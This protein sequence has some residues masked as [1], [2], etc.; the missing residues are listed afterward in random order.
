MRAGGTGTQPAGTVIGPAG[1][2]VIG[3]N[4]ASVVIPPGA[5]ATNTTITIAQTSAGS[6]PLPG[7]FTSFGPM[8]AFTPHGTTFAVPVTMTLPF[9]P[10]SVP[11]GVTPALLQDERAE[12][13]GAGRQRHV[14]RQQRERAGHELLA[15][16]RGATGPLDVGDP[17]REWTFSDFRQGDERSSRLPATG[18]KAARGGRRLRTGSSEF[19]RPIFDVSHHSAAT[20]S[21]RQTGQRPRCSRRADG[22]TYRRCSPKRPTA[23]RALAEPAG[24]RRALHAAPELHQARAPT[25]R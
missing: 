23:S 9:D 22:V 7:G 1:G 3:P 12:P 18:G 25:P 10:A 20:S 21:C 19:G 11:A 4:G 13:M 8:F 5:L 17:V 24:S 6:P 16:V 2:T 15:D 14:R